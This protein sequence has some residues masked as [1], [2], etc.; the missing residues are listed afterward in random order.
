MVWDVKR[1]TG[2]ENLPE[3]VVEGFVEESD[4]G[5]AEGIA[6]RS[7]SGLAAIVWFG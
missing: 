6:G 2:S 3:V 5:R 4:V 7:S 1:V